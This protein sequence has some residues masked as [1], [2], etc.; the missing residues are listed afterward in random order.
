MRK[1]N[2]RSMTGGEIS[3]IGSQFASLSDSVLNSGL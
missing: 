3:E 1:K 2:L